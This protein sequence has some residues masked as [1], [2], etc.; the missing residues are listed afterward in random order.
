[1][2]YHENKMVKK[3]GRNRRYFQGVTNYDL[4]DGETIQ[5]REHRHK[6]MIYN[7]EEEKIMKIKFD[8]SGYRY[9]SDDY[10][11][12]P[13]HFVKLKQFEKGKKV[14]RVNVRWNRDLQRFAETVYLRKGL[15]WKVEKYITETE[16][17]AMIEEALKQS[18]MHLIDKED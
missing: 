12:D 1:M 10:T 13:Y 14:K 6:W 15:F 7:K 4:D 11:V 9:I 2:Y 16:V 3:V 18:N 17:E 8:K 5:S